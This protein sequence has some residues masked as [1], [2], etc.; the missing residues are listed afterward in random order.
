MNKVNV[1]RAG[2]LMNALGGL[3]L[4]AGCGLA[5]AQGKDDPV[6]IRLNQ[7][8]V[9]LSEFNEHFDVAVRMLTKQRGVPYDSL[10]QEQINTLRRQYLGQ[11]ANDVVML[12]EAVKRG[13][14]VSDAELDAQV[15][16]F[17]KE[18]GGEQDFQASLEM[19]GLKSESQLRELVRE[20]QLIR[21]VTEQIRDQMVIR[22]GDV[23]VEHH[24]SE[25]TLAKPEQ[26]CM[27]HILVADENTAQELINELKAGAEFAALAMEK[28][29]DT[30]TAG[31]GGDIGCFEKEHNIPKS[32]FERAAF[33]AEVN[34]LTGP[35][36]SEFGYH[37]IV[38]YNRRA[39]YVPTLN[40]VYAELEEEIR[41]ERLPT[42]L[43][44]IRETSGVVTF[45]DVLGGVQAGSDGQ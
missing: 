18:M 42:V 35:V 29:T 6:V 21:L 20:R 11:L 26:I 2:I 40:E 45:P 13:I 10:G 39:S 23:V 4:I 25:E 1:N 15:A 9:T 17:R 44:E 27:R 31:K 7:E 12:Q 36:K 38:V 41:H 22:P 33:N 32:D 43:A 16:E 5:S 24:D 30:N 37:V 14:T 34:E 28:S 3:I 19:S 8:E